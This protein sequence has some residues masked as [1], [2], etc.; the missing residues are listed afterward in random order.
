M[1]GDTEKHCTGVWLSWIFHA[2]RP[3]MDSGLI[4]ISPSALRSLEVLSTLILKFYSG[5][6]SWDSHYWRAGGGLCGPS[7]LLR[8]LN[9]PE[10]ERESETR[11]T[12]SESDWFWQDEHLP[13]M[14]Q[15]TEPFRRWRRQISE[16]LNLLC[17][18]GGETA[19]ITVSQAERRYVLTLVSFVFLFL[20]FFLY[21]TSSSLMDAVW[22]NVLTHQK[23]NIQ[24]TGCTGWAV[25]IKYKGRRHYNTNHWCLCYSYHNM[26]ACYSCIWDHL[27]PKTCDSF[28][29]YTQ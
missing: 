24:Q 18:A 9:S 17:K 26:S 16:T 11:V 29:K 19:A 1:Q 8:L 5:I 6:V 21:L 2:V 3:W 28:H 27:R 15:Q 25:K 22:H 13:I 14:Q 23:E 4:S 7:F 12:E 10:G 20:C